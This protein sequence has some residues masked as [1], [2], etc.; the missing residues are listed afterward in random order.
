LAGPLSLDASLYEV[1][2]LSLVASISFDV[3]VS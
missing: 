1:I 2:S 3:S